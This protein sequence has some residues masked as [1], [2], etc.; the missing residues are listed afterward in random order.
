VQQIPEKGSNP[1]IT[2]MMGGFVKVGFNPI[3][4]SR[5]ALDGGYIR[6]L[7]VT[8]AKHSS[9]MPELPTLA[10]SGLPGFDATLS[11]GLL[12]PGGTPRPIVERLNKELRAALADPE[13]RKRIVLEGGEPEPTTPEQYAAVLDHE[14]TKWAAVIHS[15]GLAPQ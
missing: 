12:A 4:V 7:A 14:W 11:Y 15:A 8:S 13:V 6:A 2:D 1:L 5:A 9:L 10:E 3:P